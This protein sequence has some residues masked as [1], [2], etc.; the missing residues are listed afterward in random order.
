MDAR[1][2]DFAGLKAT[3]VPDPDGDTAF[4]ADPA[5]PPAPTFFPINTELT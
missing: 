1:L 3:G 4:D 2:Y 5:V